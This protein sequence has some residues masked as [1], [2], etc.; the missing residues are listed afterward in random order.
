MS[1]GSKILCWCALTKLVSCGY[2]KHVSVQ[3]NL[4]SQVFKG[5]NIRNWMLHSF[6][7]ACGPE[8]G[9]RVWRRVQS[10]DWLVLAWG[11]ETQSQAHM[12][13]T[14]YW[15]WS[16]WSWLWRQSGRVWFW[17]WASWSCTLVLTLDSLVLTTLADPDSGPDSRLA[18]ADSGP[19]SGLKGRQ[20]FSWFFVIDSLLQV[21]ADEVCG[22]PL[23]KDVFEPT[24]EFC[25]V[26][27]R[28]CNKHYC[29]E[30][31]RR[32]EVDLERVRV[33]SLFIQTL[34]TASSL[35]LRHTWTFL[36]LSLSLSVV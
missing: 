12:F 22:C 16:L 21:P 26:S 36:T 6:N 33:V 34:F 18:G 27:K 35:T 15:L 1:V 11:S 20:T 2:L 5:H 23:V 3:V 32:A 8:S 14:L 9:L 4:L 17:L 7:V 30:K 25:R 10:Q 28:K 24:G 31:L 13:L 29:W 19:G